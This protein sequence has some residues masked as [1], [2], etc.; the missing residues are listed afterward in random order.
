MLGLGLLKL[1]HIKPYGNYAHDGHVCRPNSAVCVGLPV[2][3]DEIGVPRE[4]F[5]DTLLTLIFK[6]L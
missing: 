1:L 6:F 2:G 3:L 4:Y 5:S